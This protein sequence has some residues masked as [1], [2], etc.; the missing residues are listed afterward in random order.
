MGEI[1][2]A[3][4]QVKCI[5]NSYTFNRLVLGSIHTVVAFDGELYVSVPG[6]GPYSLERFIKEENNVQQIMER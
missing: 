2:K 3:G 6:A 1:I 5:D 4:D